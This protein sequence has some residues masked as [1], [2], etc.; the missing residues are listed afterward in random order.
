MRG[1]LSGIG[2]RGIR[3]RV[4]RMRGIRLRGIRLR[5]TESIKLKTRYNAYSL[6][7]VL[8]YC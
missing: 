1:K 5:K 2:L 8:R 6:T 7:Q 3:L 4:I